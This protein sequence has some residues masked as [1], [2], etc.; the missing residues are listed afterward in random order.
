MQEKNI[1]IY[2]VL[3]IYKCDQKISHIGQLF[4]IDIYTSPW[5][6]GIGGCKKNLNL[7]TE[8]IAFKVVQMKYKNE[9]WLIYLL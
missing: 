5:K 2:S 3:N 4:K 1:Q 8:K 6:S 7:N 9:V